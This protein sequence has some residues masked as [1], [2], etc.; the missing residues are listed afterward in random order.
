MAWF[1]RGL[2]ALVW[3]I[4]LC[5]AAV[6][7]ATG[8]PDVRALAH[9]FFAFEI[10]A[11]SHGVGG[12]E[13]ALAGVAA[14]VVVNMVFLYPH[15][16]LARGWGREHR[17][18]ARFDLGV[19]LV[20]PYVLVTSAIVIAMANT[21]HAEGLFRGRGMGPVEAAYVFTDLLG[22]RAGRVLFDLGVLG[23]V[24]TTITMHMVSAAFAASEWFGWPFGGARYRLA[25]LLPTPGV[26]GSV[27]WPEL[28][29]Y[30]AIP[31]SILVAFFLPV[32]YLGFWKLQ[33]SRAYLGDDA[34][35]GLT[36]R[37]WLAGIALA[38]LVITA[39]LIYQLLDVARRFT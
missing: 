3:G 14:A 39:F 38:T 20:L 19:G 16:L 23:M 11:P 26:L 34:P 36:G 10:P 8:V 30:V 37:L 31:T 27:F 28:S 25:L 29:V 32:T 24:L 4:V 33:R 21:V 12:F 6:V 1:D 18:L 7:A 15:T 13:V 35:S 5:F 22:H 9:G 17:A 2:A